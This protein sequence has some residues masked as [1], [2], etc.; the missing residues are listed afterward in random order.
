MSNIKGLPK[1]LGGHGNVT[2]IDTGL[3]EFARDELGCKSILDIGCGPGG[4]VYEAIRLG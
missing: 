3:I 1:H 4:I 2:H